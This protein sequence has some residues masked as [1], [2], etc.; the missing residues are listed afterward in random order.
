M[1]LPVAA[2]P[3]IIF[4]PENYTFIVDL[5]D[6]STLSCIIAGIPLP[7]VIWVRKDADN[8]TILMTDSMTVI[9]DPIVKL[10]NDTDFFG[11]VYVANVTLTFVV[12]MEE[13]EGD[14]YCMANDTDE[15]VITE[16]NVVVQ[17]KKH[18]YFLHMGLSVTFA[19][20]YTQKLLKFCN[21]HKILQLHFLV[22]SLSSVLLPVFLNPI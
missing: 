14:Y 5:L 3:I 18:G 10:R 4:P 11:E 12:T 15:I 19:V 6:S 17:G 20:L 13:D 1:S 2:A 21:F 16:F 8:T 22:L 9:G 7:D